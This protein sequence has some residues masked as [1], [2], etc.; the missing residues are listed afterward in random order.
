MKAKQPDNEV[1][2]S[3]N[4]SALGRLFLHCFLLDHEMNKL[5]VSLPRNCRANQKSVSHRR[6]AG[7]FRLNAVS[8]L[9]SSGFG[10]E[11]FYAAI[12]EFF[13]VTTEF[14]SLNVPTLIAS[15]VVN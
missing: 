7:S 9:V 14:C 4:F 15:S 8:N 13:P 2:V 1:A 3:L 6:I 10:A 12:A 5:F 11:N